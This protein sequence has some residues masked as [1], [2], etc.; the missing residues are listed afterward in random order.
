MSTVSVLAV[1]NDLKIEI[2]HLPLKDCH[3]IVQLTESSQSDQKVRDRGHTE[4]GYVLTHRMVNDVA[5]KTTGSE[6]S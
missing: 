2:T 3:R 6:T 1:C 5:D 4:C